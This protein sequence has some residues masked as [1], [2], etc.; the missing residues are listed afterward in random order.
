MP[1]KVRDGP[2]AS[3]QWY[4]ALSSTL[5]PASS[6]DRC[7]SLHMHTI[8]LIHQLSKWVLVRALVTANNLLTWMIFGN[9]RPPFDA[10]C[11]CS[12]C[13]WHGWYLGEPCHPSML[14]VCA[15]H[16]W[17]SIANYLT[18][19]C[20]SVYL[21]TRHGTHHPHVCFHEPYAVLCDV[22][23]VIT[24]RVHS[25]ICGVSFPGPT[26]LEFC[27]AWSQQA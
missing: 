8:N 2:F 10:E 19:M 24:F 6:L 27:T 7:F 17:H 3:T 23:C 21:I 16:A 15:H 13:L 1:T 25:L 4:P 5:A 12:V 26:L 9:W 20:F 18:I 22:K 14:N 11:P